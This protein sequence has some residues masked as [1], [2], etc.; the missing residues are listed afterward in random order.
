MI[1]MS[2]D[3]Y[4][5]ISASHMTSV[6]SRFTADC[7]IFISNDLW[8]PD[9]VLTSRRPLCEWSFGFQ[10]AIIRWCR[11]NRERCKEVESYSKVS[12]KNHPHFF[13]RF[14]FTYLIPCIFY[15]LWS[16]WSCSCLR[17]WNCGETGRRNQRVNGSQ[18]SW[19]LK[20]KCTIAISIIPV[21]SLCSGLLKTVKVGSW[22]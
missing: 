6:R 19:T 4:L 10:R 5:C 2:I 18:D 7:L 8:C 1:K 9:L 11:S 14:F 20:W 17:N 13:P 12:N 16:S 22:N 21:P 15:C 3:N